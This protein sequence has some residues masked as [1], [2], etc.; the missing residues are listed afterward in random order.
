MAPNK[1]RSAL[2]HWPKGSVATAG[3]QEAWCGS[4]PALWSSCTT[5][6]N[7][8]GRTEGMRRNVS[9]SVE[10]VAKLSHLSDL[11]SLAMPK[12]KMATVGRSAAC[13]NE[14]VTKS[15]AKRI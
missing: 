4:M 6:A 1:T 12:G 14:V 8:N 3:V 5:L 10:A 2:S 9:V 11:R 13:A 7:G 15:M